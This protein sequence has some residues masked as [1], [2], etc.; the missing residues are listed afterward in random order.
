MTAVGADY[1]AALAA[2]GIG[3]YPLTMERKAPFDESRLFV[4]FDGTGQTFAAEVRQLPDNP[5][6][7]MATITVTIGAVTTTTWGALLAGGTI[8][9]IPEIY[10]PDQ[11]VKTTI[12][13]L[14]L[15]QA[16]IDALPA[17]PEIGKNLLLYWDL[18]RMTGGP[19]RLVLAGE[20]TVVGV[21]TDD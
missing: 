20:V 16:G 4:N 19:K 5:G 9:T 18:K 10:G 17:S 3:Y 2:R 11:V 14:S 15:A 1:R 21:V 13:T 6:A 12:F 7:A 8:S